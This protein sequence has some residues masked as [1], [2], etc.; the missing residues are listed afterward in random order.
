MKKAVV[1]TGTNGGIGEALWRKFS[2]EGYAVIGVGKGGDK[3]GCDEYIKSDFSLLAKDEGERKAFKDSFCSVL[4]SYKLKGLINNSAVQ[5]LG[6]TSKLSI[7]SFNETLGVN[8]V[9]PFFLSQ[10]CLKSL[11]EAD[12]SI[13]NIGSIHA[14]LTKKK[15]VAYATSK[16][17]LETMTRAMAVDIGSKVRVNLIA[18]AAIETEMLKE[19]FLGK[20]ELYRQLNDFHPSGKIGTPLEVAELAYNL[21]DY[22]SPFLNGSIIDISGGVSSRLHDPV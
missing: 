5:I 18:P 7:D 17:A 3:H 9:V 6:D 8:L 19:G 16:G 21:V 14:K 22:Y 1:I 13:V 4:S 10:I 11:E 15:F 12:G 20:D 2:A